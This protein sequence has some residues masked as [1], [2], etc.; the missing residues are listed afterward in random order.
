MTTALIPQNP[1]LDLLFTAALLCQVCELQPWTQ[2]AQCCNTLVCH[3][4]AMGE[5]HPEEET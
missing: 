4:C 5:P 1:Y 3:G 2:Q